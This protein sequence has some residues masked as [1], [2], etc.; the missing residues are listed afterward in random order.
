MKG[1]SYLIKKYL[2]NILISIDQF[3]NTVAGGDPDETISGRLGKHFPNSEFRKFVDWMFGP[4][5]CKESIEEEEGSN[6]VIK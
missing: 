5:H 4:D 3:V 1:R 2:L 6:A